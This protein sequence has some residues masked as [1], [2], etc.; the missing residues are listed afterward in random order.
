[1]NIETNS[2]NAIY[3]KKWQVMAGGGRLI[4]NNAIVE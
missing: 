3:V 1:M 2:D 4:L